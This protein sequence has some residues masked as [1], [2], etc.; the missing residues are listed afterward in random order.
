[1]FELDL[2]QPIEISHSAS[3]D[4]FDKHEGERRTELK[5]Y[6]RVLHYRGFEYK[7]NIN[8][9]VGGDGLWEIPELPCFGIGANTKGKLVVSQTQAKE[10]I[11]NYYNNCALNGNNPKNK[12]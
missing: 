4:P 2:T 1:M 6:K 3:T 12:N 10:A 9:P 11:D 7:E 5:K 8:V